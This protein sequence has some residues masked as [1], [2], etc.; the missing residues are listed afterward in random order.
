[1]ST[2]IEWTDMTTNPIRARYDATRGDGHYCEKIAPE[3]ARCYASRMQPRF[4]MPQFQDQRRLQGV[5]HY[6]SESNLAKVLD[7]KKPSKIFSR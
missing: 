2:K 1:M 4:R 6:F 7:R 5:E 3:C